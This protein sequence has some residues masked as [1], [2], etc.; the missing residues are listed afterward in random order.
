MIELRRGFNLKR[1]WSEGQPTTR[2]PPSSGTRNAGLD[3]LRGIAALSV[4]L[5]HCVL[6][7]GGLPLW[8]TRLRD[9]PAMPVADIG[10]RLLSALFPSDAAVMVFF[11]LSGHV[12]W[13]SFDRKQLRFFHDLPEYACARFYRLFPLVIVSAMPLGLLTNASAAEL[14]NNMLLLSRSINGVLWSLQVEVVASFAL[15][16]LWG[17]TRGSGWK[18]LLGLAVALTAA[19]YS[20]GYFSVFFFPAFIAG[21]SISWLP[22]RLLRQP[23]LIAAGTLVLVFTNVVFGH[24]GIT[25]FFE[26]AGATILVGAVASGR[27]RFMRA[28]LPLFLGAVSYPFYLTH[29]IG[30]LA[31]DWILNPLPAASPLLMIAER[32]VISIGLTIPMAW[33]LHVFVEDP[34]LRVRPRIAWP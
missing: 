21:A 25:R 10:L 15:F 11:V 31:A 23:W 5:G 19:R 33:L 30:L 4:A 18:L 29:V 16:A 17:L 13:Q 1:S 3:G 34:V 20:H 26:M 32:A 2:P 9:F 7:V 6:Q 22:P 28:R 8:G 12:L 14:V 27:L 24:N